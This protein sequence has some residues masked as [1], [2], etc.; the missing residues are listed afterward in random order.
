MLTVIVLCLGL[1][2]LSESEINYESEHVLT[3]CDAFTIWYTRKGESIPECP[4]LPLATG[5]FN[6]LSG[7]VY[8][9]QCEAANVTATSLPA[10]AGLLERSVLILKRLV[11]DVK[12][13]LEQLGVALIHAAEDV[14]GLSS[15]GERWNH[16][17][18]SILA[19]FCFVLF[20][21]QCRKFNPLLFNVFLGFLTSGLF[22]FVHLYYRNW[23]ITWCF[24]GVAIF[25]GSPLYVQTWLPAM[26]VMTFI[27]LAIPLLGGVL[28]LIIE[29]QLF[30]GPMLSLVINGF[31][32]LIQVICLIGLFIDEK[33]LVFKVLLLPLYQTFMS[34]FDHN[35][36]HSELVDSIRR[37]VDDMTTGLFSSTDFKDKSV[38]QLNEM[39]TGRMRQLCTNMT[40]SWYTSCPVLFARSC[41]AYINQTELTKIDQG[42]E[43]AGQ[44]LTGLIMPSSVGTGSVQRTLSKQICQQISN[45]ACRT[46]DVA[47]YC[48]PDGTLYGQA[49]HTFLTAVEKLKASVVVQPWLQFNFTLF[50]SG[51]TVHISF[52][53]DWVMIVRSIASFFLVISALFLLLRG[54][55]QSAIFVRRY[56]TDFQFCF[57]KVGGIPWASA[58]N[59]QLLV[60]VLLFFLSE[61]MV[62]WT[63]EELQK[64]QFTEPERGD[65]RLAFNVQGNGTIARI[66][67]SML[68]GFNLQ[69]KY[70]TRADSSVCTTPF[71][72]VGWSTWVSL[73]SLTGL[74]FLTGLYRNKSNYIMCRLCDRFIL[75]VRRERKEIKHKFLREECRRKRLVIQVLT[76]EALSRSRLKDN[77]LV[78]NFYRSPRRWFHHKFTP[79][80]VQAMIAYHKFGVENIFCQICFHSVITSRFRCKTILFCHECSIYLK[81]CPC[82]C[83]SCHKITI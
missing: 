51:P 49:Y 64:I 21:L 83:G 54:F 72:P 82:G 57:S 11:D 39:L 20:H 6:N 28:R 78:L 53:T 4:Q 3:V 67:H 8:E 1:I 45:S 32:I 79:C 52:D 23:L 30:F 24:I 38:Q 10:Q 36:R 29:A 43:A 58:F 9:K 13:R 22:Y 42:F 14:S 74:Y 41:T 69:S 75:R 76:E 46:I 7:K 34:L 48:S 26:G 62:R 5:F 66:M 63:H 71:F 12:D 15:V 61:S 55:I 50:D 16:R 25:M 68:G 81:R 17:V 18:Y 37:S 73:F 70:C 33:L 80:I 19:G 27:H 77:Q 35:D 59:I 44:W 65:A 2:V 56:R 47:A 60:K 40:T 31:S